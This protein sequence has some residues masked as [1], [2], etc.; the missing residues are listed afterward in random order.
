MPP[1]NRSYSDTTYISDSEPGCGAF[2]QASKS[3]PPRTPLAVMTNCKATALEWRITA[4][5]Q[6]LVGLKQDIQDVA[7]PCTPPPAKR[8]RI[9]YNASA[10]GDS[11]VGTI[12]LPHIHRSSL[13]AST[14]ECD[15]LSRQLEYDFLHTRD[16][17]LRKLR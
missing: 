5:E 2:R 3:S 14:L 9:M 1:I 8:A 12:A 17:E 16:R 6:E 15:K 7:L 13:M 10:D 4:I 11:P